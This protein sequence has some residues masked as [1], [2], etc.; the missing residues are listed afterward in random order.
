MLIFLSNNVG[1]HFV[2]GLSGITPEDE[3]TGMICTKA[4]RIILN[5]RFEIQ[6]RKFDIGDSES[7]IY[8]RYILNVRCEFSLF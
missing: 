3:D 6:Y 8:L 7:S 2:P 4:Q 1:I 5:S